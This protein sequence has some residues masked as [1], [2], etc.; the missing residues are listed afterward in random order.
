MAVYEYFC[1]TCE[2]HFE[3][4]RPMRDASE[5]TFCPSCQSEARRMLS[6]FAAISSNAT[7]V[8]TMIAGGGACA[9]GGACS[10]GGH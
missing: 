8:S 9:C 7:G 3:I 10:C 4:M 5:E 1:P 2:D 6:L